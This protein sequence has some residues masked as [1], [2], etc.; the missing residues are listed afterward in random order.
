R[1]A[2][3]RRDGGPRP[4]RP[5][6]R[7]DPRDVPAHRLPDSR[8]ARARAAPPRRAAARVPPRPRD[9]RVRAIGWGKLILLGEHAVVYGYPALAA[10]LDRGVPRA[11]VPTVPRRGEPGETTALGQLRVDVPAWQLAVAAGDDHPVARG[12]CR[13]ADAL[14]I[15]RPSLSL[16][17][18]A[19]IPA[20]A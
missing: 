17:G 19:Q 14:G 16:V 15:G 8:G 10:A 2:R 9:P 18:D 6:R 4:D 3:G 5:G 12:L 11:A 1:P 20:G 13:I 7:R